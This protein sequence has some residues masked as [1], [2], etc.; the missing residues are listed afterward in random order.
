MKRINL[1]LIGGHHAYF[2]KLIALL[3]GHKQHF[4]ALTEGA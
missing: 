2:I 3:A 1:T 4:V